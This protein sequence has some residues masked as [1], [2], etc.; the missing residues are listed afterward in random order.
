[1]AVRK[2]RDWYWVDFRFE[3]IRYRKKSPDNTQA[4]AKA[5]EATLRQRLARGESIDAPTQDKSKT[6][7]E[8]AKEWFDTYVKT[9]NKPSEQS[10]K[11]RILRVHLYPRLGK[12]LLSEIA[13]RQI[14]RFKAAKQ[15]EGLN[16][17]TINN[18]L[19]VL[20]TCLRHAEEWG[21]LETVPAI[22]RLKYEPPE[23]KVLTNNKIQDI[24]SDEEEP[25]FNSMILVALKTGMR[26]G[27]LSGL[28]WPDVDLQHGL[29]TVCHSLVDGHLSTP[30]SGKA[31]HI[32]M[33]P[34]LRAWFE[35]HHEADGYVFHHDTGQPV[36]YEQAKRAIRRICKRAAVQP[37]G[38]HCLRHTF[39]TTMLE[40]G[41][42][43]SVVRDFL[44]HSNVEMTERYAHVLPSMM[45]EAA[46]ILDQPQQSEKT[47]TI[48]ATA[49]SEEDNDAKMPIKEMANQSEITLSTV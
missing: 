40:K 1:M 9:N 2:L 25:L 28:Q 30:K 46:D 12:T 15:A 7:E 39:A 8:F 14:E 44:G 27:E 45:K 32:W 17:K 31:R 22:K 5:Y 16:P 10:S 23:P 13:T 29:I 20:G 24:L 21:H 34:S 19:A 6:F 48:R 37:I 38:W 33:S 18:A 49:E 43:L 35:D 3:G 41:I 4:G 11:E 36:T 42:S 47:G 26:F